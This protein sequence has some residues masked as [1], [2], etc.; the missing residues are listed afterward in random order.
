MSNRPALLPAP[1]RNVLTGASR[2][3]TADEVIA[4]ADALRPW[5]PHAARRA[6]ELSATLAS[7]AG[8]GDVTASTDTTLD[9]EGYHLAVT[10]D[11]LTLSAADAPGAYWAVTTLAQLVDADASTVTLGEID[12][13]PTYPH[14]GLLLDVAR[15]FYGPEHLRRLVDLI[16][17]L[18]LN[19]LHL[20]LT[21]DQGWRLEIPSRPLLTELGATTDCSEGPGGFLTLAE[22]VELQEYAAARHVE[23]VPEI[24]LPGHTH[25]L[26]V[27]YPEASQDGAT[28]EPYTGTEVGFSTVDLTSDASWD[29]VTDI[30]RTVAEH[31]LGDRIH[32]G[33]D[34]CLTLDAQDYGVYVTRLAALG[35][36]TGKHL[37]MWQ[38]ALHGDLPTGSWLQY[39]TH[40]VDREKFAG[41]VEELDL[42]VVSSPAPKAY[43]DMFHDEHQVV[44]QDWAGY[45]DL[46]TAYDW[47]PVAE[48]PGVPAERVIGVETALWTETVRNWGDVTYQ[49]LPRIAAEASVAWGS[50][51]D[52]DAFEQDVTVHVARWEAAGEVV[53][54]PGDRRGA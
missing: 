11:A 25:A 17:E 33:G 42:R 10:D 6:T 29:L 47:D 12:D 36:S 46:R 16:S 4:L 26:L 5:A 53:H 49:L 24:D 23:I 43:L 51:R 40:R 21:D 22:Y 1:R 37:T 13:A 7:G 30:V 38:E 41:R 54:R 50:P 44:G 9:V 8:A 39:W 14:R 3:I 27:A 18:R 34:E 15:H 52:F 2:T 19:S 45:I 20:H 31:T 35:V 32:L 28:R 48:L